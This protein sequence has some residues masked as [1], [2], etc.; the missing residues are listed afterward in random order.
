MDERSSQQCCHAG[1]VY[2]KSS[3]TSCKVQEIAEG[4]PGKAPLRL[5]VPTRWYSGY[6]CMKSVYDNRRLIDKVFNQK[7]FMRR[8]SK[9][10]P[11]RFREACRIAQTSTFWKR[12]KQMMTLSKPII[13]AIATLERD[14]CCI[15]M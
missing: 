3:P 12:L 5:P 9:R 8:F 4:I 2:K 1:Q 13:D 11:V 15:S 6:E 10:N 14:H 7:K